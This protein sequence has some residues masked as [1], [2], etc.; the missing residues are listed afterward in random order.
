[1]RDLFR[2]LS[3]RNKLIIMIGGTVSLL[4]AAVLA[5]VW[6]QSLTRARQIVQEQLDRSRDSFDSGQQARYRARAFETVSDALKPEIAGPLER[7]DSTAACA[8]VAR[9]MALPKN[10]LLS[11]ISIR[12][13]DGSPLALGVRGHAACDADVMAWRLPDV[14]DA[15]PGAPEVTSW[16]SPETKVYR[17]F[18]ASVPGHPAALGTYSIGADQNNDVAAAV[19]RRANADATSQKTAAANGGAGANSATNVDVV[20]WQDT[21]TDPPRVIGLSNLKL[22]DALAAALA[23]QP[24]FRKPFTFQMGGDEYE[25]EEVVIGDPGIPAHNPAR[26]RSALV[27]SFTAQMRP[28]RALEEKLAILAAGSLMLGVCLGFIFS[29]PI[30]APLMDLA[31]AAKEIGEGKYDAVEQLRSRHAE[32]GTDEIGTLS[33]AFVDMAGGLKQRY[34]MSKYMSRSAFQMLEQ[35]GSGP[36]ADRKWLALMFSDVR[37]FTAFSD[38]RDPALVIERL[39]D[40]LGLEADTVRRYGGDV[41]KFV[42]DA[43]FAWFSGQDRCTRAVAAA[44]EIVAALH[45]KFG[46]KPGTQIGFGIHVGEVVIGSMGSQDRRDYTAIGRSVNLAARL[47]SAAEPGQVLVSQAVATELEGAVELAPLPDIAAKGF[48]EPVRVF[49]VCVGARDTGTRGVRVGETKTPALK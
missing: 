33:R 7:G 3:I 29:R 47:C 8:E 36:A 30:S 31:A 4:T 49:E 40:V 42:G 45:Q 1:M 27:S 22:H 9:L 24:D 32:Q 38:D 13:P 34:A 20:L 26:L 17:I 23:A 46:G 44:A 5:T 41:D 19:M 43:M 10:S 25:V 11:F 14:H 15:G 18:A 2:N 16:T 28:F 35:S 37:G 6:A 39:N 21:D 12:R 48:P